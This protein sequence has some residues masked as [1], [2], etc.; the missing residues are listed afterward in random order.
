[1]NKKVK[2]KSQKLDLETMT[3]YMFKSI[4]CCVMEHPEASS[5]I[6]AVTLDIAVTLITWK[7]L[8]L[9]ILPENC[10]LLNL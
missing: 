9:I 6:L 2:N 1:M 5:H 4:S 10:K 7:K 8:Q 3:H